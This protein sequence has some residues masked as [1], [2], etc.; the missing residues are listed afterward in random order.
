MTHHFKTFRLFGDN[1]FGCLAKNCSAVWRKIVRL[2]GKRQTE[3]PAPGPF[4]FLNRDGCL[5][6]KKYVILFCKLCMPGKGDGAPCGGACRGSG[7]KAP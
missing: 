2:F 4:R 5:M 6:L 1:L 7:V 3:K